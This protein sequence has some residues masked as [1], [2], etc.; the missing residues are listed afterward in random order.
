MWTFFCCNRGGTPHS[1]T[2][3][4][5]TKGTTMNFTK[6]HA[7]RRDDIIRLFRDT[8]AASEGKAEG[9]LIAGL[10]T[11][12]FDRVAPDD[13][14]VYS[15]LEDGTLVGAVIFTRMIYS[16]R[17]NAGSL[18][19]LQQ[20]SPLGDRGE[21]DRS[22]ALVARSEQPASERRGCRTHHCQIRYKAGG[23]N[24]IGKR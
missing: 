6:A 10:V 22:C 24:T 23:K 19:C 11:G 16:E 4:N 7:D 13:I 20:P 5:T 2:S 8:F 1:S 3:D 17:M 12:M 9:D 21:R 14:F 18:S 15:T